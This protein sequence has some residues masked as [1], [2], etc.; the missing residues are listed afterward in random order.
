M[1]TVVSIEK[2]RQERM[3][4]DK[5]ALND[6]YCRVVNAVAEGL[7]SNPLTSIQQRVL[8]GVIRYTYGWNKAKDR[9]AAS[10]LAEFTGLRRQQCSTAL[11]QLIEA[12]VIIREGGSRSPIKINTKTEEWSFEKKA[13]KALINERVNR[14]HDLYS[15]NS[16]C[17]HSTNSNHGHTKD[18]RH[19]TKPPLPPADAEGQSPAVA[20]DAP[21][22]KKS[23]SQKPK[24]DYQGVIDAFNEILGGELAEVRILN[25][26]RKRLISKMWNYKF[27]EKSSG[28]SVSFWRRYFWHVLRSKP[29]TGRKPGFD[30]RPGFDWLMK[31]KSIARVIEGEFHQGD[32]VRSDVPESEEGSE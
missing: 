20:D 14:K 1:N 15:V 21:A 22:K 29:L 10:Q 9:I 30:W 8:W 28:N 3:S 6:G 4:D 5:P 16:N 7:A 23:A 17:G 32:D 27:S 11:N 26:P 25:E 13:T 24:P 31:E 19:T 12:G 2:A 18:K